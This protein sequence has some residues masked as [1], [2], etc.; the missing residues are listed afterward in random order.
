[1]CVSRDGSEGNV[2]ASN[3][4]LFVPTV[5]FHTCEF[6]VILMCSMV[7]TTYNSGSTSTSIGGW[8]PKIGVTPGDCIRQSCWWS[9]RM[10]KGVRSFGNPHCMDFHLEVGSRGSDSSESC[11]L[12]WCLSRVIFL[13]CTA[14]HHD[15]VS[16]APFSNPVIHRKI[17][18]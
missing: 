10:R 1:M 6:S 16:A 18:W 7:L 8:T 13:R 9:A 3:N 4:M 12:Q 15:R 14:H 5:I 2:T 17:K 11:S